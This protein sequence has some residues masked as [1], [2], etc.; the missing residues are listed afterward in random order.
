MKSRQEGEEEGQGHEISGG[1]SRGH[2]G[3]VGGG[4]AGETNMTV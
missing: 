4:G 2:Q 1:L 3:V